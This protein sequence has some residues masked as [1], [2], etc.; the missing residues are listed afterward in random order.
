MLTTAFWRKWHR[1]IGFPAALFLLFAAVTG[2]L[3]AFTEFFGEA[4][5]EREATRELVSPVT[6]RSP[7][8]VWSSALARALAT[9]AAQAGD[10]PVDRVTIQM[11]GP[12]PTVAVYTGKPAGGEDRKL[13]LDAR[14]GALLSSEA[15]ADKPFLYRLHS[16]E[17]FGDG[18]LVLA[19]LWGLSLAL[20]ALSGLVIY[21]RMRRRDAAGLRRVFW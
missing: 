7:P 13:V 1:W 2:F 5:R 3:V 20:L 21:L 8:D 17:A 9:A 11:K 15:Y 6:L 19:M 18:G 14:T 4:E 12:R 16:G 10:A